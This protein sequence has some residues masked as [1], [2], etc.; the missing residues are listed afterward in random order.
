MNKVRA[1]FVCPTGWLGSIVGRLMAIKNRER[2]EWVLSQLG[3]NPGD[4]VL[5]IGFGPGVDVART[6]AIGASVA[7]IDPSDVMVRQASRRN[8]D[9]IR[10]GRVD[11]RRGAM[12]DLPFVDAA[13]DKAYS[14]NSYQ[15]WPYKTR[16]LAELRRVM[17]P[18]GVVII[19]V[20]PRNKGATDD[21]AKE[22]GE[23]MVQALR[24]VGFGAARL[25]LRPMSPVA[26]ACAI[27]TV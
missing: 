13:F 2:S 6:A 23:Q 11:L 1:Q 22:T 25:R 5:E 8:A 18:G 20:Q 24:E 9:A 16:A 14:I 3:V 12:P 7:G 10:A 17:R 4:R 21:T 26:T 15:F 19:A 27:A